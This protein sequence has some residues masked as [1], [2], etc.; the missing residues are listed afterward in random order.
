MSPY[1]P[2]VHSSSHYTAPFLPV[3]PPGILFPKRDY[4]ETSLPSTSR[5]SISGKGKKKRDVQR[6]VVSTPLRLPVDH[7]RIVL[8][9]FGSPPV[10]SPIAQ[11]Q[12]LCPAST[13]MRC[14]Q[15]FTT[16]RERRPEMSNPFFLAKGSERNPARNPKR[17]HPHELRQSKIG[18]SWRAVDDRLQAS[19]NCNHLPTHACH[20]L[21]S[22]PP[23]A[24]GR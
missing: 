17:S 1:E 9:R 4:R 11:S 7:Y 5:T 13:F 12:P 22:R 14:A 8:V 16:A 21:L 19:A 15:P 23:C 3:V 18:K 24:G 20:L 2:T 6:S 10:K